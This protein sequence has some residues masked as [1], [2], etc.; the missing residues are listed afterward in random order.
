QSPGWTGT[1]FKLCGVASQSTFNYRGTGTGQSA[2]GSI[3]VNQVIEYELSANSGEIVVHHRTV[4]SNKV[5]NIPATLRLEFSFAC[6]GCRTNGTAYSIPISS[7][8][9]FDNTTSFSV[10]FSPDVGEQRNLVIAEQAKYLD[11][12]GQTTFPNQPSPR[13]IPTIRCDNA[14]GG[15]TGCVVPA[16]RVDFV[17]S[18]SDTTIDQA[19][20]GIL[21]SKNN[22]P[23]LTTSLLRREGDA[24]QQNTNRTRTCNST[25]VRDS[26][27]YGHTT[28]SCDE[29]PFAATKESAGALGIDPSTCWEIW[30]HAVDGVYQVDVIKQGT[31]PCTRGHVEGAKNSKVGGDLGRWAVANRVMD[32]EEYRV[33]VVA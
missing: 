21:W 13:S 29:Y 22:V 11:T 2:P 31:S 8:G 24:G 1:R 4:L 30:P 9:T 19:A 28:D 17:L 16:V 3:M 33:Q 23:G 25:F 26:A 6:S 32:Y 18:V 12:A 7:T 14:I 27:K 10:Y 20:W 15:T 5:G